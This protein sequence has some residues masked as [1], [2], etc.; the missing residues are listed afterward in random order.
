VQAVLSKDAPTSTPPA[1]QER[2]WAGIEVRR[3]GALARTHLTL[4]GAV[5]GPVIASLRAAIADALADGHDV[6]LDVDHITSVRRSVLGELHE[7]AV[8]VAPA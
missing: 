3:L 4:F 1:R 2:C 6:R 7:L 5:D 8:W